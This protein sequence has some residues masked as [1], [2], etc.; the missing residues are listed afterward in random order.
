MTSWKA[1]SRLPMPPT[2]K[3]SSPV[4]KSL[5]SSPTESIIPAASAPRT[6]GQDCTVAPKS[7]FFQSTGFK[8]TA[9]VRMHMS[10]GPGVGC[11]T[12]TSVNEPLFLSSWYCSE[13]LDILVVIRLLI[14]LDR[15]RGSWS[16]NIDVSDTG[17]DIVEQLKKLERVGS[18][19][20]GVRGNR[21]TAML[22]KPHSNGVW[23]SQ[24][25]ILV[26]TL[27]VRRAKGCEYTQRSG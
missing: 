1:P 5:T 14:F 17:T 11:G 9:L 13:V 27:S 2:Q 3:I 20:S 18:W 26:R 21:P 12:E 25:R 22:L 4:L 10:L 16:L 19:R 23:K 6:A 8:A 7:R 24:T 15:I